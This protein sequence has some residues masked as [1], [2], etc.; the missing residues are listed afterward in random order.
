[1]PIAKDLTGERF[2]KLLVISRNFSKRW[3]TWNCL[4]DCGDECVRDT[5]SLTS[6][7]AKSC[8]CWKRTHNLGSKNLR[9]YGIW[10]KMRN[11]C[12]NENNNRY[13]RYGGRGIT[14]CSEWHDYA[15]F[16]NW[17]NSNGY[18]DELTIERIDNDKN[19]CP[20]N[21][22]WITLKE[23]GYNKSTNYNLTAFG[24]TKTLTEW[25]IDNRC[26]VNSGVI[27][28]RIRNGYS[29]EDAIT[30]PSRRENLICIE[31]ARQVRKLHNK[32]ILTKDIAEIYCVSIPC[33]QNIVANRTWKE[34]LE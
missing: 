19:Y 31:I 12:Y 29:I 34:Q 5:R 33:I 7:S 1:M 9:L 3:V 27:S 11:R 18:T 26:S 13:H 22:T 4:C 21:C 10:I 16:Y 2:G 14:V 25:S 6:G 20:E 17:A 23:Q 28:K 8:N 30:T 15:N 32:G 24:E